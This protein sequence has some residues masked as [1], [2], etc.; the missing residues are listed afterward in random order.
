MIFYDIN[1]WSITTSNQTF[2]S[3]TNCPWLSRLPWEHTCMYFGKI[4]ILIIFYQQ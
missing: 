2:F 1:T 4:V 3:N